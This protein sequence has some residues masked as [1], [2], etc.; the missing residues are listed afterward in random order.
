MNIICP[1]KE[2]KGISPKREVK[3]G[4]LQSFPVYASVIPKK[5]AKLTMRAT[6]M[7][8][9]WKSVRFESK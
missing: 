5:K 4:T 6:S 3:G 9:N 2:N 1:I 7:K 8:R